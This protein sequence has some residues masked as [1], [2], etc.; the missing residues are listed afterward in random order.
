[1]S[2]TV[3]VD[4]KQL[5]LCDLSVINTVLVCFFCAQ[6]VYYIATFSVYVLNKHIDRPDDICFMCLYSL[7]ALGKC[8]NHTTTITP[9]SKKNQTIEQTTV[10]V[11][12]SKVHIYVV[13]HRQPYVDT[14]LIVCAAINAI[15]SR[16]RRHARLIRRCATHF[17]SLCGD[18]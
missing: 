10:S 16:C 17:N 13:D 12:E 9:T 7:V 15:V 4:N 2:P 11:V 18:I 1:M 6:H 5:L 3:L 14:F 8:T